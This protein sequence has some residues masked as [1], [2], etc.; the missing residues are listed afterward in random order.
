MLLLLDTGILG[1]VTHPTA[2]A[3]KPVVAWFRAALGR[4]IEFRVPEICDYEL[5]RE[6]L[7]NGFAR[8][9]G[10][11]DGYCETLGFEPLTADIMRRAAGLWAQAR[12]RG[13]PTA[14]AKE[15]DGD[16]ILAAQ[17]QTLTEVG[18]DVVVVTENIGHL[19]LFVD[20]RTWEQIDSA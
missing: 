7:L 20:A 19:G 6:L 10:L 15:L 9:I 4:N 8:S 2:D 17:A 3:N 14:D 5:R 11:L 16:V 13:R 12:K 1:K 18:H